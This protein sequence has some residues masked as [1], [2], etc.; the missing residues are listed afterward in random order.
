M[1]Q[2]KKKKIWRSERIRSECEFRNSISE[3]AAVAVDVM[4]YQIISFKF[5]QMFS[6]FVAYKLQ[7]RKGIRLINFP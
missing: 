5:P 1:L 2:Q 6:H 7:K 4:F 3:S